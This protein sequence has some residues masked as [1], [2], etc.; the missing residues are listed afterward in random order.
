MPSHDTGYGQLIGTEE[1]QRLRLQNEAV[2][3]FDRDVYRRIIGQYAAP[4]ILDVGCATGDMISFMTEDTGACRVFGIDR[5]ERQVDLATLRHPEGR[6]RVLNVEGDSFIHD[7]R[8]WMDQEG[9]TAF[10]I[11]N[12]SMVLL[13][14]SDPVSALRRLRTLLAEGGT[15]IVREIDDG[16]QICHPDPEGRFQRLFEVYSGDSRM[17]DRH[18][19]RKVSTYLK[20]ADFR[21]VRFEKEGLAN[22]SLPDKLALYEMAIPAFLDYMRVRAEQNPDNTKFQA[23]YAWYADNIGEI[24]ACFDADDFFFCV[25]FMSFTATP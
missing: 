3:H 17:G 24:R 23:E 13:H 10:D 8:T 22:I 9:V 15:L 12:C 21:F 18:C 5:V 25:G 4:D 14:L 6:F 2:S 19:G 11:I 20:A 1:D 7:M 16:L